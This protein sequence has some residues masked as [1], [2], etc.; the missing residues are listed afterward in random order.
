[1]PVSCTF[2]L[3]RRP[4]SMLVCPGFGRV[5]A[6]SGKGR[7]IDDPEFT[8]APKEGAIPKGT[9]YI[10]DRE[11]GGHLGWLLDAVKDLWVGTRREE[12]FALHCD[13]GAIDDWTFVGSVR[14]GNFRLHPVGRTG[15]S[16]GCITLPSREQFNA[17][18]SYLKAQ[19]PA[20]VPGTVTRCYGM[21]EVQ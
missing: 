9:Y 11:S 18:R 21:V 3:N 14:R 17:L 20:F 13:D 19:P 8:N 10:I 16:D 7:Y 4:M 12:W 2:T 15:E 5:E 6:F 1:M